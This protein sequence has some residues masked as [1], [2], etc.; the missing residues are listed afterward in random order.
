MDPYWTILNH[1]FV[2]AMASSAYEGA[3]R[4]HGGLLVASRIQQ[5]IVL[6]GIRGIGAIVAQIVPDSHRK[7]EN[8]YRQQLSHGE[9]RLPPAPIFCVPVRRGVFGSVGRRV[10]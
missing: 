7:L 1:T 6:L 5:A 2:F 3:D 9:V 10:S 4:L 8:P